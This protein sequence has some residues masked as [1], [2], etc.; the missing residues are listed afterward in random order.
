MSDHKVLS[1]VKGNHAKSKDEM[2]RH[3]IKEFLFVEDEDT[4]DR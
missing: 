3:G 2:A 1:V 4:A